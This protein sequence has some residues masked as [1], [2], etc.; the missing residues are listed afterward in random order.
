MTNFICK[1]ITKNNQTK[2]YMKNAIEYSLKEKKIM[3][4]TF[5]T[6]DFIN[7]DPKQIFKIMELTKKNYDKDNE[8]MIF[9]YTISF[10]KILK[11]EELEKSKD[12]VYSFL[13]N[14][15]FDGY[16]SYAVAHKDNNQ[17]HYHIIFN[18][19]NYETGN[20][21]NISKIES[22]DIQKELDKVGQEINLGRN[23][24]FLNDLIT[25][26][27]QKYIEKNGDLKGFYKSEEYQKIKEQRE[28][29]KAKN[30]EIQYEKLLEKNP[31]FTQKS[32]K[33]EF[34]ADIES[35]L[36]YSKNY[37]DFLKNLREEE[38]AV[39]VQNKNIVI[40]K[41]GRKARLKTLNKEWTN[42]YIQNNAI[43]ARQSEKE[44]LDRV[45]VAYDEKMS[46]LGD[47]ELLKGGYVYI[48]DHTPNHTQKNWPE[49]EEK[50]SDKLSER[51]ILDLKQNNDLGI[52]QV[53]LGQKSANMG[54]FES[55]RSMKGEDERVSNDFSL[56]EFEI[57]DKIAEK[58][59]EFKKE[60]WS[61]DYSKKYE[62]FYREIGKKMVAEEK[63]R[64]T[65]EI[66][67]NA[68]LIHS[69]KRELGQL[70][71]FNVRR[72]NELR[73]KINELER[74]NIALTEQKNGVRV[75]SH[76]VEL[77]ATERLDYYKKQLL[78]DRVAE[79]K[80][81]YKKYQKTYTKFQVYKQEI[82][83]FLRKNNIDFK[84]SGIPK[85][86]KEYKKWLEKILNDRFDSLVKPMEE[87]KKKVLEPKKKID[88][89]RKNKDKEWER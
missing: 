78:S 11:G 68:Y 21:L 28:K 72:K 58:E 39:K 84:S 77:K 17:T 8:K 31:D 15:K 1:N 63:A 74:K 59:R 87:I 61:E 34:K 60:I 45:K 55:P 70:S 46:N 25:P 29:S 4:D 32:W 35:S 26:A 19:V 75:L 89:R 62:E 43:Y 81:K 69:Y 47:S 33:E 36:Y 52:G 30:K 20:K 18:S 6:N 64:F 10:D 73:A 22:Y 53:G 83:T 40:E 57:L 54:K 14:E 50:K 44:E 23:L 67:S 65:K 41:N 51:Q 13:M 71:I 16:E 79:E 12:L 49:L 5:L 27:K 3:K 42:E 85:E 88:F 80:K 38:Y 48:G 56:K 37:D 9:H 24:T 2:A 76:T 82:N 66:D 7:A 86:P